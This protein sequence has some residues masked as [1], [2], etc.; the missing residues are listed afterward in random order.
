MAHL[1]VAKRDLLHPYDRS[2]GA[3]ELQPQASKCCGYA[4]N[5]LTQVLNISYTVF[6]PN[7]IG[8]YAVQDLSQRYALHCPVH[9]RA[10]D[11]VN[12]SS[13]PSLRVRVRVQTKLLPTWAQFDGKLPI[14]L[15][16]AG[17]QQV[18]QWVHL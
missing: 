4:T 5:I 11:S 2:S 8:E 7:G 9:W 13:G 12:N 14:C 18:A 1:F 10:Q 16:W 3:L 15:N 17:C 6:M